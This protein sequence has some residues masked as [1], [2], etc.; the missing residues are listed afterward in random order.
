MGLPVEVDDR[1]PAY[2]EVVAAGIARI[3]IG[4]LGV[5]EDVAGLVAYLASDEAGF[6]TG[7]FIP[8]TGG[9]SSL[10]TA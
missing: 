8:V 6:I 2:E 4:R 5:P 10:E 3:P 9:Q 1:G 7:Q